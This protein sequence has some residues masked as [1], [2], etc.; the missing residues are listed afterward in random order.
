[1]KL[2]VVELNEQPL[3]QKVVAPAILNIEA[4]RLHVYKHDYPAGTLKV[5]IT[6]LND[7]VLA[8]SNEVDIS[9][10]TGDYY[11]GQIKFDINFQTDKE[12]E[13]KIKLL[14]TGYSFSESQYI[15]WCL[16]FDFNTYVQD[17]QKLSNLQSS[18]DY[19]IW[20]RK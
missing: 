17:Y 1:M 6:D 11:H 5:Q 4:I 9:D 3:S 18:F 15:G 7:F 2:I 12:A 14:S 16:D 19:E 20:T 10:I 8:E 13:Y